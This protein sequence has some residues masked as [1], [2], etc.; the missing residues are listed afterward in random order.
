MLCYFELETRSLVALPLD[1]NLLFLHAK[2]E[3]LCVHYSVKTKLLLTMKCGSIHQMTT[4][5]PPVYRPTTKT[6]T[7]FIHLI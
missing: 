5:D 3:M 1:N 6:K 7:K 2:N 4:V